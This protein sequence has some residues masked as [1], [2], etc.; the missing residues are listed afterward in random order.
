MST[1]TILAM[2]QEIHC[3]LTFP[4]WKGFHVC[5]RGKHNHERAF[6]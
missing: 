6:V 3:L 4:D 5:P 1:E 2:G